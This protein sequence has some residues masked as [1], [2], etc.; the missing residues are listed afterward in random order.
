MQK[1]DTDSV[2]IICMWDN[3]KEDCEAGRE[4]GIGGGEAPTKYSLWKREKFISCHLQQA[5]SG[6]RQAF[7]QNYADFH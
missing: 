5:T 7:Q 3:K 4:G 2:S 6:T 1:Q